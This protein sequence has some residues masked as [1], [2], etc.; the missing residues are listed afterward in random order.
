MYEV[1]ECVTIS[2]ETNTDQNPPL[3][4]RMG[5]VRLYES[6]NARTWRVRRDYR[7][8][9]MLGGIARAGGLWTV[10]N[11]LCVVFFGSNLVWL[12]FG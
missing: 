2:N 10:L 6:S 1:Y 9:D 12:I 5:S 11:A 4:P 7:E 8:K 3:G